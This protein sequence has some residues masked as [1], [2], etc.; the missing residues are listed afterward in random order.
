M[1]SVAE[2]SQYLELIVMSNTQGLTRFMMLTMINVS[3][4][5]NDFLMDGWRHRR[6]ARR[7]GSLKT[8]KHEPSEPL[9]RVRINGSES[10]H[11]QY[12]GDG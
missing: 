1:E 10:Y 8:C 6:R 7:P 3:M 12:D 11:D 9:R 4:M 2:F 5:R